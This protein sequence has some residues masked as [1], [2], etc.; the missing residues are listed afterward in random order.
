MTSEQSKTITRHDNRHIRDILA[1]EHFTRP[2][3]RYEEEQLQEFYIQDQKDKIRHQ[4][5]TEKSKH[6]MY[7]FDTADEYVEQEISK[8]KQD[9]IEAQAELS[10]Y[11]ILPCKCD[12]IT[13]A[14][15]FCNKIPDEL[16]LC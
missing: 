7:A 5:M 3:S 1:I 9:Y 2:R 8:V 12:C 4:W 15:S 10:Q 6:F 11:D 14:N 13:F 16:E